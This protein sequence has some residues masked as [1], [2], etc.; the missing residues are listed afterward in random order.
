MK[1]VTQD[2]QAIPDVLEMTDHQAHKDHLDQTVHQESQVVTDL[3]EI[4][5]GRLFLPLPCPEIQVLL[6]T[7]DLLACLEMLEN[8][9]DPD[10]KDSLVHQAH[11]AQ[12]DTLDLQASLE[13]QARPAIQVLKE[14]AVSVQNTVLWMA[15]SSL[16]TVLGVKVFVCK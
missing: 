6:E 10:L 1:L 11:L 4:Q 12:A 16:K 2:H 7:K 9:E 14:N 8:L 13:N 3:A 5:D 15:V